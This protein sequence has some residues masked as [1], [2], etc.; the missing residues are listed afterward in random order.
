MGKKAAGKSVAKKP[1]VVEEIY[2]YPRQDIVPI[3]E[4]WILL[5]LRHLLW[6]Y[7]NLEFLLKTDVTVDKL[8]RKI[9]QA[10]G[11]VERVLIFVGDYNQPHNQ[12]TNFNQT[13][14]NLLQTFGSPN[15]DVP[16][17]YFI[18]YDFLP[19]NPKDPVL[20]AI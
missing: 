13:L 6:S 7:A 17:K 20:L 18:H 8:I 11:R 9:Q 1:R 12:I 15:K 14:G 3:V 4:G 19:F 16:D 5:E 2:L 10:L